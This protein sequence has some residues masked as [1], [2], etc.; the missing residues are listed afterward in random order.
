ME[1]V[2]CGDGDGY[3]GMW[4]CGTWMFAEILAST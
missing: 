1:H 3:V 2:Q 4:E